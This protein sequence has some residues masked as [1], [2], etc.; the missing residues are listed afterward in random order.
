M[1]NRTS[2]TTVKVE[3]RREQAMSLRRAGASFSQIATALSIPKTTAYRD[4]ETLLKRLAKR[5]TLGAE[6]LRQLEL[7]RLDD[8]ERAARRVLTAE[9]LRISN[10]NVVQVV[11]PD[12]RMHDVADD[13]PVLQAIDRL[14]RV[15][16]RRC[17]LLGLDAPAKV[18]GELTGDFTLAAN[19][20]V[21]ALAEK[22]R[23]KIEAQAERLSETPEGSA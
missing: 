22:V 7:E 4:V 11:G 10:G 8:L 13:A 23:A 15:S 1:A 20:D 16:E 9:H 6:E 18:E 3:E 2:P 19:Q 17:K 5:N 12:G 21:A 14:V